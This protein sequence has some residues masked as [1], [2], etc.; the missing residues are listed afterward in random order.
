MPGLTGHI[1]IGAYDSCLINCTS[2]LIQT[3][4]LTMRPL[5]LIRGR[6]IFLHCEKDQFCF[7]DSKIFMRKTEVNLQNGYVDYLRG[8]PDKCC[9]ITSYT[10]VAGISFFC[11]SISVTS[12]GWKEVAVPA[13]P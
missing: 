8:E 3:S 10:S 7:H 1:W 11:N 13:L 9:Q 6:N 2:Q 4:S 12:M 5:V